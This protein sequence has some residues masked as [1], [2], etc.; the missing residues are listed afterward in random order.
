KTSP[1]WRSTV[2]GSPT[3][4][5]TPGSCAWRPPWYATAS[6][7]SSTA[8]RRCPCT[9]PSS[10]GPGPA[11]APS[12]TCSPAPSWPRPTPRPASRPPPTPTPTATAPWPGPPPLAFR[13]PRKLLAGPGP[14]SLDADVYQVRRVAGE[15][16]AFTLLESFVVW[17]CPDMTTWAATG[18]VP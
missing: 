4:A 17:D 16:G 11:R 12:P 8:S 18:Y 15:A 7:R 10:A 2:A 9:S 14:A 3:W 13:A 6:D 5:A 1:G